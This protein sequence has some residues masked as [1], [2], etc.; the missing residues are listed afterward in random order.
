MTSF[1]QYCVKHGNMESL[2]AFEYSGGVFQN[3]YRSAITSRFWW[4]SVLSLSPAGLEETRG[5]CHQERRYFG[6]EKSAGDEEIT[7]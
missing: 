2:L 1:S 7:V 3:K 4:I 5:D 6:G